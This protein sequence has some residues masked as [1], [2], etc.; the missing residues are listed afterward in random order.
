MR[1]RIR[2]AVLCGVETARP[3]RGG[4]EVL[5]KFLDAS[6]MDLPFSIFL[7]SH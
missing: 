3:E 2:A 6:G 5:R 7:R 1:N 4:E